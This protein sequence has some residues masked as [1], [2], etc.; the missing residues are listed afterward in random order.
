MAVCRQVYG[1]RANLPRPGSA[2]EPYKLAFSAKLNN[3]FTALTLLVW[4]LGFLQSQ[5]QLSWDM[6]G[7]KIQLIIIIIIIIIV[8]IIISIISIILL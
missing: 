4:Q 7:V 2:T 8:V 1:L 3:A 5:M 6:R